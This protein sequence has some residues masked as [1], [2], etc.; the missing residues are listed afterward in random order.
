MYLGSSSELEVLVTEDFGALN[1][2]LLDPA[3][4]PLSLNL[5]VSLYQIKI[6]RRQLL[7]NC[8]RI[9]QP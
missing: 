7:G 5:Q 8:H 3:S 9:I 1:P 2:S 6:C 4:E